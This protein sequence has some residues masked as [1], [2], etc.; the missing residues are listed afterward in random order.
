MT[1]HAGGNLVH[2]PAVGVVEILY[3]AIEGAVE[4]LARADLPQDCAGGFS[5]CRTFRGVA[6]PHRD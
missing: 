6:L 5:R 1:E 3:G 4:R 2:E